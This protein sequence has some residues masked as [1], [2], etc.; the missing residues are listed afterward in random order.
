V[1]DAIFTAVVV[2]NVVTFLAFG[3]DKWRA[4]KGG[5]RTPE[6][7]LIALSFAT[8]FVGGWLGMRTFRHKTIKGSFR[9]KMMLVTVFNPA[10][11]LLYLWA[12]RGGS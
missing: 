9:A 11:V 10:W 12:T 3:W 6:A 8:G 4:R 5:W 2:I 1:V 7:R